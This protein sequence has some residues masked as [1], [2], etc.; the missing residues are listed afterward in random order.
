MPLASS[1]NLGNNYSLALKTG[2]GTHMT[3]VYVVNVKQGVRTRPSKETMLEEFMEESGIPKELPLQ[4]AEM[5]SKRCIGVTSG[6]VRDLQKSIPN[7][8]T[9]LHFQVRALRQPHI[10][11]R[12]NPMKFWL[13]LLG[14]ATGIG[15]Y[16]RPS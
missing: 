1:R 7:Y 10:D 9:E 3:L 8:L 12:G 14:H 13:I 5:I 16:Q 2:G 4:T 15:R 6:D 11:L